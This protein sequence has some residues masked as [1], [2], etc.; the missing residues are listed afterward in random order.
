MRRMAF[1]EDFD[2]AEAVVTLVQT[3]VKEAPL[4]VY[5]GM[6]PRIGFRLS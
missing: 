6:E 1:G 5:A 2:G 3:G 4:A